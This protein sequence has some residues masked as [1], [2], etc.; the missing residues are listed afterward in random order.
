[1][2]RVQL[3]HLDVRFGLVDFYQQVGP[4]RVQ[5]RLRLVYLQH[6]LVKAPFVFGLLSQQGGRVELQDALSL[7]DL[8]PFKRQVGHCAREA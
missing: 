4:L 2:S 5:I 8:C 3:C 7:F 6:G 1:M